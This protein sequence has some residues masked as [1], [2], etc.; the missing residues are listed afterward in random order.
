MT[1]GRLRRTSSIAPGITRRRRGR[2]F[3]YL[4]PNGRPV[5][6]PETRARIR[7]LAIPPAWEDVWICPDPLGHLQA[8]G[9]D[10]GGRRQYL[11]HERW[12]ERRDAQKFDRMIA[13]ARELPV[14]RER[15]DRDLSADGF[16][17]TKALACA[18]RLLDATSFRVGS[19]SYARENGSYGLATIRKDHVW[20][21]GDRAL[22]D[23][24]AKN[25]KR[26]FQE[27]TDPELL[28]A[29]RALKRRRG[30]GEELLAFRAGGWWRDV[31]SSDVNAYV[32]E[33]AGNGF[34]AKDFRTWHATV[35][36]A[37]SLALAEA[38]MTTVTSGRRVISAAIAEVAGHLGNTP[39]VARASYVDPRVLD[40]FEEGVTIRPTL[41]RLAAHDLR[42]PKVREAVEMAVLDLLTE[43]GSSLGEAA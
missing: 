21:N 23:F 9:T 3:A 42:D 2:G 43:G 22:F 38:E 12:R 10:A 25:G 14:V 36:A 30:G 28:P 7:A 27:V 24:P 19:E 39:A 16:P 37:V 32:K 6:D 8:A 15:V 11:Y 4:H 40:R 20:V 33:V 13:F 41:E 29:L 35:L 17:K 18:V 26:R 1:V 31:R 5:R 34:S